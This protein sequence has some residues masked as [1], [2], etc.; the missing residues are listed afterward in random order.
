MFPAK[1]L[2]QIAREHGLSP[3]QEQVF[4]MRFEER[5][6]YEEIA[7][8]LATSADACLKRMGLVYKK[9]GIDGNSRGKENK[10]RIFLIERFENWQQAQTAKESA[11]EQEESNRVSQ[12]TT[13]Q[14]SPEKNQ[15]YQNLP[16]REYTA[17]IG[18]D[19]ETTRLMELL[20][21]KHSA[22]LISVDGIGGVGKTTLVVEVA[23]RCL[24]ASLNNNYVLAEI[25]SFAAI[26]FASAKQNH[27]TS[28]GILPRLTFERTLRDIC[29][30][31]ARTLDITEVSNLPLS[32]HI[33]LIRQKLSQT[34]TLLI[35]DNLETIEDK[36]DVLS[37][38]YDLPPTV[39][40]IMTTREQA[41]FVPIRLGC[42]SKEHGLRLIKHE[43]G[44][45]GVNLGEEEARLLFEGVSGI[46]AAIIYAIGQM[47]SGYLLPDVLAQIKQPTGDIAR[48]FFAG[49]VAPLKSTPAHYL[50]MALSLFVQ[51]VGR[52]TIADIAFEQ[53]DPIDTAQG[54]AKLHQLS[55][56]F[57]NQG[58]YSLLELTREYALAE[59]AANREFSQNLRQR[60]V[61]WYV[62]FSEVYGGTNWKE[63]HFG[64]GYLEAEWENLRAVLEWCMSHGR[65]TDAKAIWQHIKGYIHVRGFWDERLD[66]TAWLIEAAKQAGDWAFAAE[67]MSDR[68][69]TLVH[70]RYSSQ[71]Q[72]AEHL[73]QAAWDLRHHQTI[74]FQ[75]ELATNMVIL[76]IQQEKWQ[77]A[78]DWLK[79]E[80]KL[81]AQ[82]PLPES[83]KKQQQIHINY[84]Q[85][86]IFF[87]TGNTE[88][89]KVVLQQALTAAQTAGWQ[90]ATAAIQ[91]WL[92]DIAV[93]LED[94][95]AA[96][97]L[98]NNSLPMAQRHKDKRCIA[99]HQATFAK[100]E[101]KSGNLK[102]AKRWAK[103][104][105]TVFE[106]LKMIVEA[107][108]MRRL[109]AMNA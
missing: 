50:L 71:L 65:Y 44:E 73:L 104:A 55:L 76:S 3:Q 40:V 67:V 57:Q 16:A 83:E 85:G 9:L 19:Q 72:E 25:P 7:K 61:S 15:I 42:L 109:L 87:K 91:N 48:F 94:L 77:Q 18:R 14:Q 88:S 60:W 20:N 81:L 90:R 64:Y 45:K 32:E 6:T 100:L 29:R 106:S 5:K 56:V 52:E 86:Q 96:R 80:E 27:L 24:E 34:R 39:K 36:Q 43:A 99:F 70:M 22:H 108:E 53:A 58:R 69:R 105:A 26:I 12:P 33:D 97:Q 63:W 30:E 101:K 59:L 79:E 17:F 28:M 107:Q 98:L 78:R 66:W 38:L 23:Y 11:Y 82:A 68:S 103:E 93:E 49:A 92:A 2:S 95:E 74:K 10:L 54:L 1:F 35:I 4:L 46:P 51:P 31:I 47:A 75:L 84:Y 21:N 13:Q 37:F 41:L 8:E 102:E 62:S 89:A